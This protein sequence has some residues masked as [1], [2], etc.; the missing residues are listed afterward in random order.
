MFIQRDKPEIQRLFNLMKYI[1]NSNKQ[2]GVENTTR[3]GVFL[4]NFEMLGDVQSV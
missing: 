3:S 1:L 2:K 4:T